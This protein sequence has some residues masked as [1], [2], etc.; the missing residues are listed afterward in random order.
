MSSMSY[1]SKR[2]KAA[3]VSAMSDNTKNQD[4]LK[5][6]NSGSTYKVRL[7]SDSDYV[8]YYAASAYKIFDTTPVLPDNLYRKAADLLYKDADKYEKAGDDKK[9]EAARNQAYQL[10]PKPRYLFGF[11]NLDDGQPMIID[12]TKNQAKAVIS[13]IDKFAKRIDKLAF[14]ISKTG[15]GTS[16]VVSLTPVLDMEEDLTDKQRENFE[17]PAVDAI[18]DELFESVLKTK[19]LE[20][21]AE[22]L[23]AFGFDVSRLG[24]SLTKD[25]SDDEQHQDIDEDDLEF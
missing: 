9:A 22:D 3:A 13:S 4:V 23:K 16:T 17:K 12:M 7:L 2:G 18:P 21:Q 19:N 25:S 6:F 11:I 14:E 8:E 5:P 24:I 20:E 1:V 15:S 10:K